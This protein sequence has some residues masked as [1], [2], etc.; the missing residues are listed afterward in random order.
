MDNSEYHN[1]MRRLIAHFTG[2]PD[3][4]YLAHQQ[5][6][7][8]DESVYALLSESLKQLKSGTPLEY[9]IGWTEF[10]DNKFSV[11]RNVLIPREET[12]ILVQEAIT[13]I[14]RSSQE[15]PKVLELGVGSGAVIT[16]ILLGCRKPLIAVATDIS[17]QALIEAKNNSVKLGT[18]ITFKLGD[19]WDALESDDG[20]FDLIVANP[21]YVGTANGENDTALSGYEPSVSLYGRV[22]SQLGLLDITRIIANAADW[23]S[24]DGTLLIE[25][26]SKQRELIKHI[27]L[28]AGLILVEQIDD[29]AGLPRVL[30]FSRH[31]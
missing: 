2:K 18:E 12:E 20:P 1:Y 7:L 16:S 31:F 30:L 23:L 28:K 22:P 8:G 6:E 26:G 21:P 10:Y 19:W 9:I 13:I 3:Y 15:R 11:S 4:W 29:F 27:S 5:E 17:Q 24:D 14:S 25:H